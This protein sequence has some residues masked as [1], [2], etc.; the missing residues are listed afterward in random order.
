MLRFWPCS[1]PHLVRLYIVWLEVL[2]LFII[3]AEAARLRRTWHFVVENGSPYFYLSHDD[4]ID[5]R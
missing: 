4:V 1:K 5:Q 2:R 3:T